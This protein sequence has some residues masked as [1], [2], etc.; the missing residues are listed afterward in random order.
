M[1]PKLVPSPDVLYGQLM[2]SESPV[3][4]G[5]ASIAGAEPQFQSEVIT[6]NNERERQAE[7]R[8]R[9]GGGEAERR[10]RGGGGV[11]EGKAHVGRRM[12]IGEREG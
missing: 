11:A 6:A 10:R 5:V 9:G 4:L 7:G 8:R 12:E 2:L 1:T 3:S